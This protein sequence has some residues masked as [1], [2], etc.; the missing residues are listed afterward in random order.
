MNI[1]KNGTVESEMK[2]NKN[3]IRFHHFEHDVIAQFESIT[4]CKTARHGVFHFTNDMRYDSTPDTLGPL[5][6]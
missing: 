6:I 3:N 1:A 4:K 2:H 5:M